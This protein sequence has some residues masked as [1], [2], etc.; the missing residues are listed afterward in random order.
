LFEFHHQILCSSPGFWNVEKIVFEMMAPSFGFNTAHGSSVAR[1]R[2]QEFG[3]IILAL[4]GRR[5]GDDAYPNP[6]TK[7]KNAELSR[8]V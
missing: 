3:S 4:Q 1:D 7:V 8:Y 2:T 6:V 5:I